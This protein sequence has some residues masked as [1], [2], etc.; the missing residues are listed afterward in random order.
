MIHSFILEDRIKC[1]FME[2]THAKRKIVQTNRREVFNLM[3]IGIS[4]HIYILDIIEISRKCSV[5][6]NFHSKKY[7]YLSIK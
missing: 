3:N 5:M 1:I 6:H 2:H 4:G 7:Q